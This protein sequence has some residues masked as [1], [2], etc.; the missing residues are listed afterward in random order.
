MLLFSG[1]RAQR[2]SVLIHRRHDHHRVQGISILTHRK[3]NP[4]TESLIMGEKGVQDNK[5]VVN[6]SKQRDAI[7]QIQV[8]SGNDQ[9]AEIGRGLQEGTESE[10]IRALDG[11]SGP[12]GA[13]HREFSTREENGRWC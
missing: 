12:A 6:L 11:K 13:G 3:G 4:E 5:G 8:S 10:I 1:P 9:L 7:N 2:S